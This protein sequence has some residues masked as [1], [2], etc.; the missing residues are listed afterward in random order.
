MKYTSH[1]YENA[2]VNIKWEEKINTHYQITQV[3]KTR[4]YEIKAVI[5]FIIGTSGYTVL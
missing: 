4:Q 1:K 3:F 2:S 5:Y